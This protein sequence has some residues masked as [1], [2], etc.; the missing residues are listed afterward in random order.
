MTHFF[1]RWVKQ[2]IDVSTQEALYVSVQVPHR[3]RTALPSRRIPR[4]KKWTEPEK[5][6]LGSKV[7]WGEAAAAKAQGPPA[8]APP[9]CV[10]LRLIP[11]RTGRIHRATTARLEAFYC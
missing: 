9:G 4:K 10:E 6:N 11:I 2:G 1:I 7:G 5:N 3:G 8:P